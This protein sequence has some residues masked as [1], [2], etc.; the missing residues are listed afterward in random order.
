M[1]FPFLTV[2]LCI[3]ITSAEETGLPSMVEAPGVPPNEACCWVAPEGGKEFSLEDDGSRILT[4]KLSAAGRIEAP[5]SGWWIT[6]RSPSRFGWKAERIWP[7][8]HM[9]DGG[10][11]YGAVTQDILRLVET[12]LAVDQDAGLLPQWMG[13]GTSAKAECRVHC[14][15]ATMPQVPRDERRSGSCGLDEFVSGE[16]GGLPNHAAEF[17]NVTGPR[18]ADQ[19]V[20]RG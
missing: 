6:M 8:D 19:L 13:L 11:C 10:C 16:H 14:S 12:V 20:D 17:A 1:W 18:I 15:H 5:G 2:L 9:V 4:G 7:C 3:G